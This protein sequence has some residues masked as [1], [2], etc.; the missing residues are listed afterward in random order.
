MTTRPAGWSKW[1][2]REKGGDYTCLTIAKGTGPD[3]GV[4]FVYYLGLDKGSG[5]LQAFVRRLDDWAEVMVPVGTGGE[6][7]DMEDFLS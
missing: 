1:T 6:V 5:G 3:H 2:H 7:D 4:E